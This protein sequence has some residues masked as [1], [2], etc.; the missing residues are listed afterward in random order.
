[1]VEEIT[2]ERCQFNEV[3]A[4]LTKDAPEQAFRPSTDLFTPP[5]DRAS[6]PEM[7][8]AQRLIV[9]SLTGFADDLTWAS[10]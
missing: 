8:V 10:Y 6:P 9:L 2:L 4:Q 5:E 1:M 3:A 7:D